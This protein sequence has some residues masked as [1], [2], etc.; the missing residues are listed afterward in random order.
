[1]EIEPRQSQNN[2]GA[3]AAPR[4]REAPR[5]VR[6]LCALAF[7]A[8]G[9]WLLID[10]YGHVLRQTPDFEYFYKA[11]AWFL[12]HGGLDPGYDQLEDGSLEARGTIEWYLP[13]VSRLMTVI[14]WLP[15][16][17]A[18]GIW[19]LM[20][21]AMAL[22]IARLIGRR[23]MGLPPADWPVT[24]IVPF[25]L[26]AAYWAVEFKL[27]QINTL[28]LMLLVASFVQWQDGRKFLS[29]FWLGLAVLIKL[30]PALV[31]LWFVLKRQ[32]ATA[33]TAAATFLLAG[34]VADAIVFGPSDAYHHY[35]GWAHRA[36]HTGSHRG[37][38]LAQNETDWRNQG[39]GV[40]LCR[41][42]HP[43]NWSTHFDNEPRADKF[44]APPRLMN[45][46]DLP[47]ERIALISGVLHLASVLGLVYLA[48]KPAAA[49]S[50]WQ[51]RMEWALFV[52]AMLW[53]MPVMRQY[54]VIWAMPAVSMIAAGVASS[55]TR[56]WKVLALVCV[57][58]V[59]AGQFALFWRPLKAGGVTL[60]S[61]LVIALPIIVLL[62]RLQRD[63]R[64]IAD[65]VIRAEAG[66]G[67]ALKPVA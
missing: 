65:D 2:A 30:T 55:G 39:S 54:H 22:G 40:V 17:A 57:G 5:A 49:L 20:N 23:M 56:R 7:A 8:I 46:A 10:G 42:L 28:T 47:L 15:F 50:V 19:V 48:R 12:N 4:L 18:G 11:G 60:A 21:V 67:R 26:L 13:F 34:P 32:Y 66:G 14:A 35:V 43:T 44:T 36:V 24:Q 31:A 27:N 59:L 1:M 9:V 25:L 16:W 3:A 38:I 63:P 64:A 41:W 6:G 58:L 52:L 53:L 45:V 33:A 61:V 37:L 29:G 51:L 62:I